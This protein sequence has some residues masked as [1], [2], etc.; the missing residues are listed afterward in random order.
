MTD[1]QPSNFAPM[2]RNMLTIAWVCALALLTF[3][4]GAWEDHQTNPNGD[5]DSKV[6]GQQTTVVLSANRQ[7]H[8]IANGTINGLGV[9][10]L[11]DTGATTVS[12]PAKLA[13]KL[14][15]ERGPAMESMTANGTVTVY[16]T[17]IA[18]L[19]LGDITLRNI[20]G[21]I[22]P[23]MT[24]DEILLGMSALKQVEMRQKGD[25]L[26]LIQSH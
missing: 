18:K 26:T 7:H 11:L 15:L 2:G 6:R 10:F 24:S 12:V 21:S 3:I 13:N 8:Y 20:Q 16:A 5:P 22:N 23:G 14:K 17:R 1:Q 19:T 25:R 4:F 9:T